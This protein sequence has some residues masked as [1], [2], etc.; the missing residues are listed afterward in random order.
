M[1]SHLQL[2]LFQFFF[3]LRLRALFQDDCFFDSFNFSTIIV[4]NFPLEQV[5]R[6]L[7]HDDLAVIGFH[8]LCHFCYY[9]WSQV[10]FEDVG[11]R[12]TVQAAMDEC[13]GKFLAISLVSSIMLEH[14]MIAQRTI[15]VVLSLALSI[16]T[17]KPLVQFNVSLSL[18]DF[19][20]FE[21]MLISLIR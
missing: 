13:V 19:A 16:W 14:N 12:E 5:D 9:A 20:D 21:S 1:N 11:E 17:A 15:C 3:F 6:W 4:K 7:G 8:L 10:P 18:C 2:I